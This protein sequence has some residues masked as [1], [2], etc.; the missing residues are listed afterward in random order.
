VTR[1]RVIWVAGIAA[2]FLIVGPTVAVALDQ[3]WTKGRPT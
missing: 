1:N 2:G 3:W